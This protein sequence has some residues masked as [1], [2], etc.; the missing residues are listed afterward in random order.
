[1]DC[2]LDSHSNTFEIK[3]MSVNEQKTFLFLR[4]PYLIE[5]AINSNDFFGLYTQK[6]KTTKP[7]LFFN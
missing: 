2:I 4:H 1:M 5:T 6:V 7:D 3:N